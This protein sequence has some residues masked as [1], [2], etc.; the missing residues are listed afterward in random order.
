MPKKRLGSSVVSRERREDLLRLARGQQAPVGAS[1]VFLTKEFNRVWSRVSVDD[2]SAQQV[3]EAVHESLQQAF[4]LVL[5]LERELTWRGC[6]IAGLKYKT[7]MFWEEVDRDHLADLAGRDTQQLMTLPNVEKYEDLKN[8]RDNGRKLLELLRSQMKILQ[9][10]YRDLE[11]QKNVGQSSDNLTCSICF[12]TFS[13]GESILNHDSCS[14]MFHVPCLHHWFENCLPTCPCCRQPPTVMK[15]SKFQANHPALV[16]MD[17]EIQ[18]SDE[19]TDVKVEAP[20][21]SNPTCNGVKLCLRHGSNGY[22]FWGCPNFSNKENQCKITVKYTPPAAEPPADPGPA[23]MCI[24]C[25]VLMTLKHSQRNGKHF[26]GCPNYSSKRCKN[27][28]PISE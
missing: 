3:T 22:T 5:K 24:D 19:D 16:G 8:Q 26:W 6:T 18:E 11:R 13:E 20:V 28:M 9:Q 4:R 7:C 2:A 1:K 17:Q 23:P 12:E 21:C 27:T 10:Q 14:A 25:S 15:T